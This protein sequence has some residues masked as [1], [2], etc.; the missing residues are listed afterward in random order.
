MADL[1]CD[2]AVIGAGTAGLAAERSARA[3]GAQTLLIDDRFAGT[4]C[5][6][7][8]CMPSK[9]MIAAARAA[10][11]VRSASIF[12]INT[13]APTI[14]GVAVMQRIRKQ[15][16]AFIEATIKSIDE[17]PDGVRQ[18]G[19]AHFVDV[20]TLMLDDGRQVSAKAIVIATGARPHIPL[21]FEALGDVVLTNETIFDLIELPQSVAVI[22]SGPLG[23]ELAQAL[24]RLGVDTEVF[25]QGDR[26]AG[27]HDEEIAAELQSILQRELPIHLGVS[28]SVERG[29]VGATLRWSGQSTGEK[30]FARVLVATGRPPQLAGLQLA[31]IGL[32][33]DKHGTPVFDKDTLQC[34]ETAIFIAGDACAYRPVLHEASSE[35][36][37]AG[38]NAASFPKV[39][40]AKRGTALS[41]MFTDPPTAVV[42][43]PPTAETVVGAAAYADQGR[44]KVEARNFGLVH[45]YADRPDGRLTGAA[46]VGPGM[47]HIAHLIAWAIERGETATSVLELPFYHPTFEEGLKSA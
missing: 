20:A 27:L 28:L 7:V 13:Q 29:D 26:I 12:G 3:A 17:I 5:A 18:R 23:L 33:L 10:H 22:G 47:D 36:A 6:T 8:G 32:E 34:G 19:R 46:M 40:P 25:E 11:A 1:Y 44:A 31:A 43:K 35:G 38:R 24:A 42:G 45:L 9:L 16:D 41:I 15:R 14:D 30:S 39:E 21:L 2:V 4:T 37:I